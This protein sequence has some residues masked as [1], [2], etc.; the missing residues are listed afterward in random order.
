MK[1]NHPFS[2]DLYF[3][4]YFLNFSFW[5]VVLLSCLAM[6]RDPFESQETT[7]SSSGEREAS[8]VLEHVTC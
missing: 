1:K 4:R 7:I 6:I 8:H 2:F 3:C 5:L